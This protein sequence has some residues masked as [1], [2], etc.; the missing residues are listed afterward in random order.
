M[1]KRKSKRFHVLPRDGGWTVRAEGDSRTTS[2]HATQREAIEA[3]REIARNHASE[4]VIHGRD[5]RIRERDSYSPDPLPPK[6]PR[7]VLFPTTP[8]VTSKKAIKKAVNEVIRKS[9]TSSHG[10]SRHKPGD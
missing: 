8:I 4:L 6:S 9:K 2:V 5:G 1:A 3:A 10:K 7:E